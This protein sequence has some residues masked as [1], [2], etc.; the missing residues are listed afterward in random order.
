MDNESDPMSIWK[1]YISAW[2]LH[3]IERVLAIVSDSFE[4][5]ESPMTM[6]KS[7]IGKE[8]FSRYLETVFNNLPDLHIE[9]TSLDAGNNAAWSESV[10]RGTYQKKNL[11][12]PEIKR[13][14]DVK[15]ACSF[16]VKAGLLAQENLYWDRASLLRQLGFLPS[17]LGV[18]TQ[19]VWRP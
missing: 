12:F 8:Q 16:K 15:V 14:M 5:N 19:P 2:N 10:M 18:I 9:I 11:F 17:L 6:T 13:K 1:K 4:Y 7:I 3:D